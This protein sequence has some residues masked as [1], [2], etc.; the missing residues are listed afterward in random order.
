MGMA[1]AWRPRGGEAWPPWLAAPDHVI[2]Q[3]TELEAICAPARVERL[4]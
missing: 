3:I 2:D 4:A 1:T